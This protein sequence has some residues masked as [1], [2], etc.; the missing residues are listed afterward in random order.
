MC[1]CVCVCKYV[2]VCV[3]GC[4]YVWFPRPPGAVPRGTE[5]RDMVGMGKGSC[6]HLL[7]WKA[8][9]PPERPQT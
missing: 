6:H 2:S 3:P 5:L 4:V 8:P 7:L 9:G 1:V